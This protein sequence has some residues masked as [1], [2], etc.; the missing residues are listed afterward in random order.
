MTKQKTKATSKNKSTA[1]SKAKTSAKTSPRN[2]Q[3]PPVSRLWEQVKGIFLAGVLVYILVSLYGLDTGAIGQWTL[4]VSVYLLGAGAKIIVLLM[5]GEAVEV[6]RG[7]GWKISAKRLGLFLLSLIF[8]IVL[9]LQ[10]LS[11]DPLRII[12]V[13][14]Q[15]IAIPLGTSE[16]GGIIGAVLAFICL[17]LFDVTGTYVVLGA[18][19][20]IGVI[21][22]LDKPTRQFVGKTVGFLARMIRDVIYGIGYLFWLMVRG[23]Q[24]VIEGAFGLDEEAR[25]QIAESAVKATPKEAPTVKEGKNR[26][27]RKK[28]ESHVAGD[29][30][31]EAAAAVDTSISINAYA[32]P[33]TASIPKTNRERT[34]VS[35]DGEYTMPSLE[36]LLPPDKPGSRRA[37]NELVQLGKLLEETLANFGIEAKVIHI[38]CG[39]VIT[40]YELQPAPGIKVSRIVNLADD[41]ALSL[42]AADIR[43]EAP[44]PGKAAIGIEV[45]NKQQEMVKLSEVIG[46][47]EFHSERLKLPLAL[48]KGVAGDTEV[49]DLSAMPH[50]LIAGATGSGKS[51]CMNTLIVSLLYRLRPD[52]LRILMVDPKRV[53]LAVY[54][55][56]PHLLAPVITDPKKA[57]A[58]LKWVVDE[59]E[60]RYEL[61]A[62]A[63]VR[64]I[65]KYN[66]YVNQE[67]QRMKDNPPIAQ[68][69]ET[70]SE[71][72]EK[73]PPEP[74]PYVVVLIDELADLMMVA[75][76]DV[77]DAVCRLA[78]M[79]RAA[80]IHLVVAT[81]RP[82]V[83]V[84]T[85]LI[86]ANIPARIAFAVSS[87]V[88]SRT[89]L[90]CG[91]AERLIGKGDMLYLSPSSSKTV[92]IQGAYI[93]DK[94][95]EAIAKFWKKQGQPDYQE[96]TDNR[97]FNSEEDGDA[98]DDLFHDAVR[99]VVSSGQA[100]ISLLQR[101]FRIG[102]SRAA[103]LM[104]MMELKGIVGPYQGSKPREVLVDP[105]D[106]EEF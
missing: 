70:D 62:S 64:N 65:E 99:L 90:D 95:I 41:I 68:G 86:K 50:L 79:A 40:R 43:I 53:E 10:T 93:S 37:K 35:K 9:H 61:F 5:F 47:T 74:L 54:D 19:S 101:R 82:S 20:L 105:T 55:G 12:P 2:E 28:E 66:E 87:Q 11:L 69:Q 46:T 85:G 38:D 89:I 56:I 1:K 44:I 26:R 45:P 88:D 33:E 3:K 77:E 72:E 67:Q 73:F 78:Q 58:A 31:P 8:L 30:R 21:L 94:E 84:I 7:R 91:G 22:V 14:W 80:G 16:G 100:S 102:H 13:T 34:F 17:R 92:R 52:Q 75:S 106:G 59:M 24:K 57:A 76:S 96:V 36:L 48:G 25:A 39:P 60:T 83:D 97:S 42:A 23:I 4:R 15:A 63:G 32:G 98:D 103:R 81:Q 29:L 104:D 71:V 6:F 49:V 27:S 18:F 51:V